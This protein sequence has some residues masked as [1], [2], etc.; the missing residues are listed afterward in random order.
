MTPNWGYPPPGGIQ[1]GLEIVL[2]RSLFRLAV[3]DRFLGPLGCLLGSF[4]DAFGVILGHL[5]FSWARFGPSW[6][7]LGSFWK[8]RM[9][10]WSPISVYS[11]QLV[12]L[13]ALQPMADQH[14]ATRAGGLR[15]AIK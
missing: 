3:W 10:F 11:H 6:A 4:W 13:S 12:N 7:L 2:V 14:F 5:G 8:L 15:E 9:A 1:G